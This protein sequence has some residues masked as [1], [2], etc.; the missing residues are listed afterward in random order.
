MPPRRTKAAPEVSEEEINALL[1]ACRSL[2][3]I[4]VRSLSAVADEID[5]VELR[6]LVVIASNSPASLGTVAAAAGISTS[7]AS[8][9]C[10]R[11]VVRKLVARSDDPSDRRSLRLTLTPAGQRMIKRVTDARR[12]AIVPLLAGMPANR[13]AVA[14]E[15]LREL[16][17]ASEPASRELWA[18][19]WPT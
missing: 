9:T 10:D 5:I 2:V 6:I 8:R 4:S 17:A 3:A 11:L 12:A 15:A 14:V 16:T 19:G 13:R 1:D 18:M 7:K